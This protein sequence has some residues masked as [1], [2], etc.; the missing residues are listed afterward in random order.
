[1]VQIHHTGWQKN[2]ADSNTKDLMSKRLRTDIHFEQ[3]QSL[4]SNNT[5]RVPANH[6][7]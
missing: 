2:V 4:F 5:T 7:I 3:E 6:V 1:M